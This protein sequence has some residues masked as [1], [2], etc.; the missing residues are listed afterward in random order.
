MYRRIDRIR[1]SLA[2]DHLFAKADINLRPVVKVREI[3][4]FEKQGREPIVTPWPSALFNCELAETLAQVIA[5]GVH[6][7]RPRLPES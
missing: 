2:P 4:T 3:P 5:E 1:E 6:A 7:C